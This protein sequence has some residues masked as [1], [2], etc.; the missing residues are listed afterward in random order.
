MMN[1]AEILE[2]SKRENRGKDIADL[3]VAKM[4]IQY[5]WL[6][7]VCLL[8]VVAVTEAV[9]YGRVNYG[10]F[11]AVTAGCDG[12]FISKYLKLRK[13]HE[14]IVS[15]LYGIAAAAFL[16]AWILGLTR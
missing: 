8:A 7:A 12:I 13:R 1:K 5:G 11:F 6:I 15:I 9:V 10:I 4:S 3:E 16:I 2:M 14:L